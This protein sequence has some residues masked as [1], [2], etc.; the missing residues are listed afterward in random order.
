VE[1]GVSGLGVVVGGMLIGVE[2]VVL[3]MEVM[4]LFVSVVLEMSQG[5]TGG[6]GVLSS[7]CRC[8]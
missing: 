7:V 2:L 1:V 5:I 3:L 8:L 4:V 6:C